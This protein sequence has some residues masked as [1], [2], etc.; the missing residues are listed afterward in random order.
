MA[1][2]IRQLF[3]EDDVPLG[4]CKIC[5]VLKY[6]FVV[7]SF[8]VGCKRCGQTICEICTYTVELCNKGALR[9]PPMK[10][11]C[12]DVVQS[13][14]PTTVSIVG[15]NVFA[16]DSIPSNRSVASDLHSLRY[17]LENQQARLEQEL[18]ELYRKCLTKRV[19]EFKEEPAETA[20]C[21]EETIKG[22]AEAALHALHVQATASEARSA[23]E[24]ADVDSEDLERVE[25]YEARDTCLGCEFGGWEEAWPPGHLPDPSPWVCDTCGE[26]ICLHCGYR[27]SHN[28]ASCGS[29]HCNL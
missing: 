7:P 2:Y 3:T 25:F 11:A 10:K 20:W 9:C 4:I 29:K 12:V 14:R 28:I 19:L 22:E 5:Q 26:Q 15:W 17:L 16:D 8:D 24:W 23:A 1:T 27:K 13:Q 6:E 18:P 21:M